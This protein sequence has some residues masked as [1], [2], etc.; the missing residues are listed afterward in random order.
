MSIAIQTLARAALSTIASAIPEAVVTV[1]V[2]GKTVS[3]IRDLS[4]DEAQLTDRGEVGIESGTVRFNSSGIT[5]PNRGDTIVVGGA[6]VWVLECRIDPAG[7]MFAIRYSTQ[8][9]IELE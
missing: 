6:N 4:S 1:K 3:A 5:Q 9:P 7:A 2:G 8:Q